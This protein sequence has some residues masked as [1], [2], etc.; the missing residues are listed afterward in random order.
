[1]SRTLGF[2]AYEMESIIGSDKELIEK[3]LDRPDMQDSGH[4]ADDRARLTP[5]LSDMDESTQ[6]GY[7]YTGVGHFEWPSVTRGFRGGGVIKC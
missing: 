4:T 2:S 5:I 7:E 1:M 6:V 3:V